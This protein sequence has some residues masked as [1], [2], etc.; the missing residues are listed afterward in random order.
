MNPYKACGP[1]IY[2]Q[3]CSRRSCKLAF[4]FQQSFDLGVV[5]SDWSKA[6]VTAV[7]KRENKSDPSNSVSSDFSDFH[8]L[9]SHGTYCSQP[10]GNILINEQ[11]GFT[12]Q[13]SCET[14]LISALHDWAKSINSRSQTDVMLLDFSKAFDSV[15]PQRLLPTKARL[16][17]H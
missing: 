15:P 4:I 7:F 14:Q 8:L 2:L 6:L 5:P 9:Q 12:E 3:E 17:W 1:V 11:R 13:F 16:L 10:H